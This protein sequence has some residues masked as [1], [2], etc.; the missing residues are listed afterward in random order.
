MLAELVK[1]AK[2]VKE[3]GAKLD[4]EDG[5]WVKKTGGSS[6]LSGTR[7]RS[8]QV[9]VRLLPVLSTGRFD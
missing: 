5:E 8:D 4:F 7:T 9:P 6:T 3:S 1:W 2:L